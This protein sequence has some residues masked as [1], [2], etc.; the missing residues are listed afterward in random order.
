MN[1][2]RKH[3]INIK[4]SR[5]CLYLGNHFGDLP[6]FRKQQFLFLE[7]NIQIRVLSDH[8]QNKR[9]AIY[10]REKGKKR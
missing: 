2:F 1:S 10:T 9:S 4:K 5:Y 3:N 7:Q 8:L 6:D